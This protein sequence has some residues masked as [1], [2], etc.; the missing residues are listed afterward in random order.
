MI[1]KEKKKLT[2]DTRNIIKR[3]QETK[4]SL[5]SFLFKS[6]FGLFSKISTAS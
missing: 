3:E 1:R 2:H 6:D 4:V 5:P